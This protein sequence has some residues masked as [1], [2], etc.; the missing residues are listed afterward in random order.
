MRSGGAGKGLAAAAAAEG[1]SA[2]LAD[3]ALAL[4]KALV[5]GFC[6]AVGAPEGTAE[7]EM[8]AE[9]EAEPLAC[10]DTESEVLLALEG[11]TLGV[12]VP[13]AQS[14]RVPEAEPLAPAE[15]VAEAE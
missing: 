6:E 8:A 10:E 5:A 15:G 3:A 4:C 13:V 9:A 7:M 1:W 2:P 11:L 14:V 12:P